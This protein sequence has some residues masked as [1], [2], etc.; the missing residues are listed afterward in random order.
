MDCRKFHKHLEDYLED[1]LDFPGRFGVERHAQQC[2][3]CGKELA[4]AQRLRRMVKELQPVKAPADFESAVLHEIG[5]RKANGRFSGLRRFWLYG[6]ELPPLRKLVLASSCLAVM[7]MGVF[8]YPVLSRRAAPE[9][10]ATPPPAAQESAIIAKNNA[11]DNNDEKGSVIPETAAVRPP[12]Q[13]AQPVQPVAAKQVRLSELSALKEEPQ[14]SPPEPEQIAD[15]E[16]MEFDYLELQWIGPDNRPVKS[17]YP[18]KPH[19]RYG[20]NPRAYFIRYESH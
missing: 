2:I 14:V 17:R 16:S 7:A 11:K 10:S 1:G 18:Y 9:V 6:F 13:P 15:Q 4:N 19:V 3:S 12:I 20:E 5:K 8:L